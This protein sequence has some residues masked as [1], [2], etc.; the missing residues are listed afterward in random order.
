MKWGSEHGVP[1]VP[2]SPG[3]R[4]R[5]TLASLLFASALGIAGCYT[6]VD[7]G[8]DAAGA[9]GQGDGGDGAD[10]GEGDDDGG[11]DD[12]VAAQCEGEGP[13]VGI[14]GLRLLTRYEYDNTVRDLL[15]D[16]TRPARAFPPENQTT[17][18]E[19]NGA[20]H[21]VHKDLVRKYLDASEEIAERAAAERLAQLLPCDP[22]ATGEAQ[23]GHM[24]VEGLLDRAFRRP[25]TPDEVAAFVA[26]FD[27]SH[28]QFGFTEAVE[29]VIQ[30]VLQS[31]QFLY[32]IELPAEDLPGEPE[33]ELELVTGYEMASRLSYFLVA[34][35]PDD[36]LLAAAQA[37]GLST[38]EEVEAQARR[39]LETDAGRRSVREF[40]RQWLDLSG[41]TSVSKDPALFPALDPATAGE[42]WLDSVEAFTEHVFFDGGG[43]VA[44]LFGS[45][46]AF[47]SPALAAAYGLGSPDPET[48]A[49]T[50][51][52]DRAGLLTQPGLMALYARPEQSSPVARGVFVRERLLCQHLPPPPNDVVIEA[53]DP[54]PSATTRERFAEH[55]GKPECAGCHIL[56]D[57]IGFGFEHYDAIG[58]WRTEE[59]GLTVDASGELLSVDDETVQG[60]F[61]G[62][63]ELAAKLASSTDF[64]DCVVHQWTTFALGREPG[65]DDLC[66]VERVRQALV[67]SDG[68]LR[69]MLVAIATSDSFRY[70]IAEGGAP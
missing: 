51:P 10:D 44:D 41:L 46:I 34:S 61:D 68:D 48:G 18:F 63:V 8:R 53:P 69:E 5:G 9:D 22:L 43:T 47:M 27:S 32:R 56:I 40:H 30:A 17:A 60:E 66:S 3:T 21:K 33:S 26:L 15:G 36:E 19:N 42:A 16:T 35:M 62:A 25:A 14:T 12:G 50:L 2:V 13:S 29:L 4:C 59:N 6:G 24:F 55:T 70:R 39:L 31:P 49:Y 45:D 52:G 37:G 54:D 20:D 23:C 28:A 64:T 38:V 65:E 11:D 1:C 7:A 57:P 58:K 67:E